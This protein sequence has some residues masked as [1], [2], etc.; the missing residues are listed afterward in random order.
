MN[1]QSDRSTTGPIRT[2]AVIL[3]AAMLLLFAVGIVRADT[4]IVV[5]STID[6]I[7]NDGE[8][9]L[10]EA[11]RAANADKESG[12]DAGECAAGVAADTI[13]LPPGVYL[14]DRSDNGK[15]DAAATGDLDI[16]SEITIVAE[17]PGLSVIE[18]E[19]GFADRL[20]HVLENGSLNL[21]GV[22]LRGAQTADQGAGV[23]NAGELILRNVTITGN[24]AGSEGG[25]IFS[26]AGATL[27]V[28]NSTISANQSLS[29]GG[30]IFDAGSSINLSF[31]TLADNDAPSGAVIAGSGEGLTFA[32][33][34]M[35]G[36]ESTDGSVDCAIDAGTSG[37]Y[38]LLSAG[39]VCPSVESDRFVDHKVLF[40][41]VLAP[42]A[43]NGGASQTHALLPGSP[44]IDS[45]PPAP[46]AEQFDQRGIERPGGA[47]CDAGSYEDPDPI[48][49]GPIFTVN[50]GDDVEDGACSYRHCSLREAILAA[51]ARANDPEAVDEIHFALPTVN[52]AN[53]MIQPSTALPA[54]EDPV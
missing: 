10:R 38:N 48:Q 33:S 42:L 4:T 51:N 35:I 37:G 28:A 18:A 47:A 3:F 25:A 45:G 7:A 32:S 50:T 16:T 23:Y 21:Q 49:V 54:V 12:P 53:E 11:V 22:T 30:A 27:E 39:S 15:E 24:N 26:A 52:G 31:V 14:L 5:N 41:D 46:C 40:S 20:I 9:T 29:S 13:V 6:R 17:G 19:A 2:V 36:N 1:N 34:I 44:A 8:C 43:L